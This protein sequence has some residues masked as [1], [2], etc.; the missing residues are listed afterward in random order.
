M[1][2]KLKLK[3]EGLFPRLRAQVCYLYC[4]FVKQNIRQT[5]ANAEGFESY[6]GLPR[7]LDPWPGTGDHQ[8]A[9]SGIVGTELRSSVQDSGWGK[10][11]F[12]L[13]LLRP[14]I[15]G[16]GPFQ[17]PVRNFIFMFFKEKALGLRISGFVNLL[18]LSAE[19]EWAVGIYVHG[20]FHI[21]L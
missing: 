8:M 19:C 13:K 14:M 12:S 21:S 6:L 17:D 7:Q 4:T 2:Q 5:Q 20:H 15:Q 11:R 3:V 10:G 1:K 9:V 16:R 18:T